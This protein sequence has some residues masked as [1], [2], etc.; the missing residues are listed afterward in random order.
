MKNFIVRYIFIS[1][2]IVSSIHSQS[3]NTAPFITMPG[4]NYDIDV[5]SASGFNT[6]PSLNYLCWINQN[7]TLYSI[8]LKKI[9][10]GV[11]DNIL[12]FSSTNHIV[13]PKTAFM[14]Y[15]NN[16]RI[17]WLMKVNNHWQLLTRDLMNDTLTNIRTIADSLSDSTSFSISSCHAAWIHNGNILYQYLDTLSLEPKIL[18]SVNCSELELDR[19]DSPIDF[20]MYYI[21]GSDDNKP[22]LRTRYVYTRFTSYWFHDTLVEGGDNKNI[23]YSIDGRTLSYQTFVNGVWKA[24]SIGLITDSSTNITFNCE[25]PDGFNYPVLTKP[26]SD[27]TP[28]FMTYDSDSLTGNKEI[29]FKPTMYYFDSTINLSKANGDDYSPHIAFYCPFDTNYIAVFWIHDENGKKDIWMAKT[30]YNPNFGAVDGS[31]NTI[32][33]F[34]LEQNYPNPFNPSTK[35]IYQLTKRSYITLKVFDIL[36]NEIKTL[37]NGYKPA[38]EYTISFDASRLPSGVYFYQLRSG[39]FVMTKKMI[40]LK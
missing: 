13:N 33:N 4:N 16:I 34:N 10:P 30:V 20:T 31:G 3:F 29:Y 18:D 8:E 23:H 24:V 1:L 17:A 27:Y 14:Q 38:G 25:N 19:Y 39:E 40:I 26:N 36:G 7:D 5:L 22:I 37:A 21:K 2:V 12:I 35:I 9:S 32:G 6:Q 11:S 15:N 28:S